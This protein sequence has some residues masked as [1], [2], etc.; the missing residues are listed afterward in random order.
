VLAS[1][2]FGVNAGKRYV[3]RSH[4]GS[5]R[6][7]NCSAEAPGNLSVENPRHEER[8][9]GATDQSFT[10]RSAPLHELYA[11]LAHLGSSAIEFNRSVF[12]CVQVALRSA[13]SACCCLRRKR[14]ETAGP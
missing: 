3:R 6:V 7:R 13:S 1:Y 9:T 12:A 14:I 8:E 5:G 2:Y 4:R 10:Q 11:D